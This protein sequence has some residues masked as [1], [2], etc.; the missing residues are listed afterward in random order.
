MSNGKGSVPRP[1][2]WDKYLANYEA[3]FRK[4]KLPGAVKQ[5]CYG[6]TV[7]VPQ[8]SSPASKRINDAYYWLRQD[9]TND[10]DAAPYWVQRDKA[11]PAYTQ[12]TNNLTTED[13]A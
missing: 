5:S 4:T 1:V 12:T 7:A 11:S 8:A 10:D 3:I 13:P 6:M 9:M 2:N